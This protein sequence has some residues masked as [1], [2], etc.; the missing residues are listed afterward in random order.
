MRASDA[1]Q[2]LT[3]ALFASG[4]LS[5]GVYCVAHGRALMFPGVV[6]D[7]SKGCFVKI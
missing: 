6:K 3:E 2:N 5:P 7:R 4:V 1:L